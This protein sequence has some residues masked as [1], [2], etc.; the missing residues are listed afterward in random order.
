MKENDIRPK[1]LRKELDKLQTNDIKKILKYKKKFLEV[2]CPAC[3]NG[4]RDYCFRKKGFDFV[5]C[6]KCDTLFVSPRPTED[7]LNN[8]YCLSEHIKFFNDKIYKLSEEARKNNIF[9]PRVKKVIEFCDK[10]KVNNNTI[11]DIGAGFGSFG[12]LM[13]KAKKFEKVIVVEPSKY[14]AETCRKKKLCTI[15]RSIEKVR[16]IKANV[17]TCFELIEHLFEPKKF[18][19]SCYNILDKNGLL[20]L[21]TVNIE[22]FDLLV[23][24]KK[25]DNVL[26]PNHLNYFNID[27][28]EMLLTKCKFKI[29]Q[30]ETPREI[31]C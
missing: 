20:I 11:I 9:K 28:L 1:E 27:S 6:K 21:T 5:R 18:L 3:A 13:R 4:Q 15:E 22:G 30:I 19:D 2:N 25:S 29:L 23:L 31:R 26:A 24:K 8:Y 7:I 10:F 17:I 14:L 16:D 12:E